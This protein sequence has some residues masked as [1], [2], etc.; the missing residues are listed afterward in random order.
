M[1]IQIINPSTLSR[2]VGFSHAIAT[3]G[4]RLLFLAGQTGSDLAGR[5]I[6]PGNLVSQFDHTLRN[7][8][9]IVKAAGGGLEDIVKLNL[10]VRSR[11]DYVDKRGPIG[12]VYRTHFGDHYPTMALFEIAGLFQS[13]AL[14]EIEGIAVL[15]EKRDREGRRSGRRRVR[16]KATLPVPRTRRARKRRSR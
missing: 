11:D 2:P 16:T 13:D 7:L 14:I 5:I 6:A 9:E 4:G 15:P 8:G 3:S 12:K 1:H 10:F